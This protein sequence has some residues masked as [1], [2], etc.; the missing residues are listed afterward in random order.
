M[1][2]VMP[3]QRNEKVEFD[4]KS[5]SVNRPAAS[6]LQKK[7]LFDIVQGHKV[8]LYEH[9]GKLILQI[10]QESWDLLSEDVKC[11]YHHNFNSKKTFF[12]V[13]GARSN[14]AVEYPAWWSSIPSFEPTE[15][16]MDAEEDFM[17]YVCELVKNPDLCQSLVS[18]WS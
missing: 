12:Q 17:A 8:A 4:E 1:L 13:K 5:L 16:E 18:S 7:G 10:D 9:S 15:P 11:V 3:Y 6:N 2:L 14:F